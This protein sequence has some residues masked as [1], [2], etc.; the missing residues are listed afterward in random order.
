MIIDVL[1]DGSTNGRA[2]AYET[3]DFVVKKGDYVKIPPTPF[4]DPRYAK[5]IRTES[6][7]DGP[8]KTILGVVGAALSY[9]EKSEDV[10]WMPG[11]PCGSCGSNNTDWDGIL[12][13]HCLNC[14]S[15]NA[16][17]YDDD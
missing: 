7:Y 3:G 16:D 10:E 12:G 8:T 6:E 9:Q 17:V 11:F 15:E 4:G 1:I 14:G 2:Y 13:C 5:V